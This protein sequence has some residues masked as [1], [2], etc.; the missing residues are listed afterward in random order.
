MAL[1]ASAS[2]STGRLSGWCGGAFVRGNFGR[3]LPAP[4]RQAQ[5]S[6]FGQATRM[7]TTPPRPVSRCQFSD[8]VAS[9]FVVSGSGEMLQEEITGGTAIRLG[10]MTPSLSAGG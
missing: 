8:N 1:V 2:S 5:W 4:V 9:V 6:T 7:R 3:V 10:V